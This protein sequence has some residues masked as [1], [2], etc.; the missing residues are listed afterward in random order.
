MDGPGAD[1]QDQGGADP[2][3]ALSE[4]AGMVRDD[5]EAF[6]DAFD[7]AVAAAI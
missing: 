5:A 3:D 7:E 4:A 1:D 2:F 6:R